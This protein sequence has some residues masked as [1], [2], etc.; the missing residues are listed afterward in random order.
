MSSEPPVHR[1]RWLGISVAALSLIVVRA[2]W[3]AGLRSGRGL[4]TLAWFVPLVALATAAWLVLW[5]TPR[6]IFLVVRRRRAEARLLAAHG[7]IG[8]C[9]VLG[10][11]LVER[12]VQRLVDA[13]MES[14][15]N[16]M[17]RFREERG[18]FPVRVEDVVPRYLHAVPTPWPFNAGCGFNYIRTGERVMLLRENLDDDGERPCVPQHGL[19]YRFL[20][21]RWATW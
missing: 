14:V 17:V 18:H 13:R 1:V 2:L 4:S 7:L 6:G 5:A 15:V 20:T 19:R 8:L 12:E 10:A 3:V 16:A 21:Q 9:F 11:A